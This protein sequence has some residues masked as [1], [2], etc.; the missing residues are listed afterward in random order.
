MEAIL[1]Q[2]NTA[3][4]GRH[5]LEALADKFRYYACYKLNSLVL[6]ALLCVY[7]LKSGLH[8]LTVS[9]NQ[10]SGRGKLLCS[11]SKYWFFL[12]LDS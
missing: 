11:L 6:K 3:M 4:P 5:I 9:V 8:L 12:I 1:Q 7:H 2:H 10:W